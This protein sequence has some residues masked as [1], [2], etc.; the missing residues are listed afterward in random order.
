M[1]SGKFIKKDGK[2]TFY[3]KFERRY[4]FMKDKDYKGNYYHMKNLF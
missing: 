2:E 3:T 1:F 4:N